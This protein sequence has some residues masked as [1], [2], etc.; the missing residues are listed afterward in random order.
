MRRGQRLGTNERGHQPRSVRPAL[1]QPDGHPA[2][3]ADDL[4]TGMQRPVA[5]YLGLFM[6]AVGQPTI[7][8]SD[9]WYQHQ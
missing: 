1:P 8:P 2:S 4:S 7:T 3:V 9:E 5:Q 6:A